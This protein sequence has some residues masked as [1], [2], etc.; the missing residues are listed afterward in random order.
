MVWSL[1]REDLEKWMATHSSILAWRILWTEEPGGLQSMGLQRVEQ[2]WVTNKFLIKI[3]FSKAPWVSITSMGWYYL[4]EIQLGSFIS[5]CVSFC[6]CHLIAFVQLVYRSFSFSSFF[7]KNLPTQ[8]LPAK[9]IYILE[10]WNSFEFSLIASYP[11]ASHFPGFCFLLSDFI[12]STVLSQTFQLN[13]FPIY[14]E[15]NLKN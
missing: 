1:G 13:I 11:V 8:N 12:T 5:I 6:V 3:L 7:N 14:F 15:C 9:F 2:D 10:L 4:F